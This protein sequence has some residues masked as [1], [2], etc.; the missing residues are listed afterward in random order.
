MNESEWDECQDAEVMVGELVRRE[1]AG[2]ASAAAQRVRPE[3]IMD[4]RH[5]RL[6]CCHATR[7][8]YGTAN[9]DV[10][11]VAYEAIDA[12]VLYADGLVSA[13]DLASHCIATDLWCCAATTEHHPEVAARMSGSL[14]PLICAMIRDLI[15]RQPVS[16]CGAWHHDCQACR[17]VRGADGGLPVRLARALYDGTFYELPADG[18]RMLSDALEAAG[19]GTAVIEHLRGGR[20]WRGCRAVDAVLGGKFL[21]SGGRPA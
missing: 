7:L 4:D 9:R 11:P 6:L 16:L 14:Q 5:R 15:G 1:A 3:R 2:A 20:H 17:A 19:G 18:C 12:A 21:R 10:C 8:A 13:S